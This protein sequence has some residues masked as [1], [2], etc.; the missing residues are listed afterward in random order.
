MATVRNTVMIGINSAVGKVKVAQI[1]PVSETL[2]FL[3][4]DASWAY[5]AGV[6]GIAFKEGGGIKNIKRYRD[7]GTD[8]AGYDVVLYKKNDEYIVLDVQRLVKY[9][10]KQKEL[11]NMPN[12]KF[13]NAKIVVADKEKNLGYIAGLIG[14]I[15]DFSN[16]NERDSD[17]H[18]KLESVDRNRQEELYK[19]G[20]KQEKGRAEASAIRGRGSEN[21]QGNRGSRPEEHRADAGTSGLDQQAVN[22]L[23]SLGM[24]ENVSGVEFR[25]CIEQAR[26]E[27]THGACVDTH[28][29]E[30]YDNMNCILFDGGKAGVAVTKDGNIVSLFKSPNSNI[31]GYVKYAM[32][33]AVKNGG[34]KLDC[35]SIGQ[36]GL[37]YMYAKCG[38]IPISY[39]KFDREF[40]PENWNYERDGEPDIVF[41]AYCGDSVG[42]MSDKYDTYKPSYEY[43][44]VF[45]TD[46]ETECAYDVAAKVRD[47]WMVQQTITEDTINPYNEKTVTKMFKQ[48]LKMF[49]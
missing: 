1:D 20:N 36:R 8:Y 10:V 22:K 29:V 47:D 12:K 33:A 49:S 7:F 41:M 18:G 30:E 24:R 13:A 4:M 9:K 11:T 2:E 40:A 45:C 37:P 48:M 39:V 28:E 21:V 35:Y 16:D 25:E 31:H 23:Y 14:N 34:T 19:R 26:K 3:T 15:L 17:R 32:Q 44:T 42:T 46:R 43:S 5:W 27:N 6:Q 38:F